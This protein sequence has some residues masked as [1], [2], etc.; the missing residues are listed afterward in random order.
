M[1]YLG[2]L[3]LIYY[4][5]I[6]VYTGRK[7]S[8]FLTF[9]LAA[10]ITGIAVGVL[11]TFLPANVQEYM[12]IVLAI[13]FC[14]F[15]IV[16]IL[17][18]SAMVQVPDDDLEYLIVLGAQVRGTKITNSLER[19]LCK[20]LEYLNRNRECKVIVSGGQ[21][22]GEDITEAEAMSKYL[23]D[24]G[25]EK[26]R[27]VKENTS[28]STKENLQNSAVYIRDMKKKVGIVTNNF[29]MYR[30]L[31]IGKQLG[32]KKLQGLVAGTNLVLLLNYLVRE[33]F[34]CIAMW[35]A[36]ISRKAFDK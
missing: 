35:A 29:H 36:Q 26:H 19:R 24:C 13:P 2:I 15:M 30:A 16:E 1:L 10:G 32:Y 9:W 11:V 5:V 21:G 20:A 27:I 7:N 18:C 6:R 4:V 33:F 3:C 23:L 34:G 28:K 14:V 31:Q 22:Q 17:I 8:T 12:R 25:I